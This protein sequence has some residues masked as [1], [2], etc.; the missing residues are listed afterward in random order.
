MWATRVGFVMNLNTTGIERSQDTK[1]SLRFL[2]KSVSVLVLD[3]AT[4]K[5]L[6]ERV[7]L[8]S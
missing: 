1:I 3:K 2:E 7:L 4:R 5:S 6:S 8:S